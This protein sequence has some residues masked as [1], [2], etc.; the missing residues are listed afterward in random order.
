MPFNLNPASIPGPQGPIGVS[1]HLLG[2]LPNES[3]LSSVS[4]PQENQAYII[5]STGNLHVYDDTQNIWINV[6]GIVGPT[7]PQGETGPS[8]IS[9]YQVAVNNGFNGSITA[10]VNSLIGPEGSKGDKGDQGETGETG[11]QGPKGDK[12]DTGLT[13]PKG[14]TGS[15]GDTGLTGP[16]GIKGDTGLTGAMGQQGDPGPQGPT[17]NDGFFYLKP[18]LPASKSAAGNFG[19]ICIDTVNGIMY[20]CTGHN[21]WMKNTLSS[22]NFTNPGGFI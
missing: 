9:A 10:W 22:A 18:G 6:G 19:E 3:S 16:Q 21:Q 1:F 4:N 11:I 20:V 8:G 17:G 14:D 7:G 12:G 5:E 15:K 13:G 2:S